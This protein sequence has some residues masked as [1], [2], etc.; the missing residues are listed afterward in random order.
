MEGNSEGHFEL[1]SAD[2]WGYKPDVWRAELRVDVAWF[3]EVG[4][5]GTVV[6]VKL[7]PLH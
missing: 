6:C 7:M 1:H 3:G 5:E 2:L 4:T